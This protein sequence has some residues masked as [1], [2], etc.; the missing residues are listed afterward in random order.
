VLDYHPCQP[1]WFQS[2]MNVT[3]ATRAF[4]TVGSSNS[5]RDN[6]MAG[7][8]HDESFLSSCRRHAA[9]PVHALSCNLDEENPGVSIIKRVIQQYG[10]ERDGSGN[11]SEVKKNPKSR[12]AELSKCETVPAMI[13][14]R[15]RSSWI[16]PSTWTL[17]L[18]C[19]RL[20]AMSGDCRY[21]HDLVQYDDTVSMCVEIP[22]SAIGLSSTLKRG[23]GARLRRRH[24]VI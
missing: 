7:K 17:V 18:E 22:L 10:A 5:A 1:S 15:G 20:A 4:T 12:P 19:A 16:G 8:D 6:S 14:D 11:I 3:L 9:I 2:L 21:L 23:D 24:S 13:C